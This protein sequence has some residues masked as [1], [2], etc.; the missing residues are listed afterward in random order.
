MEKGNFTSLAKEYINRPGYSEHVLGLLAKHVG[1]NLSTDFLVADVGAGTGKLTENLA[2]LKLNIISIEPND[3]MRQEGIEQT[4]ELGIKWQKGSGEETGLP[5]ASA[6]WILMGSSFHWV[7]TKK[8]LNEFHRALKPNGFFTAIW[9]PRDIE[10]N[11][12]H[13]KIEAQIYEIAPEINRVSSG[14]NKY[15]THLYEDLVSTGQFKDVIFVEAK[16]TI[17]MSQDRYL[18]AWRSV[19]D[20]Q[21]QAGPERFQSILS[22]IQD[23][24][25]HLDEVLVPYRTRSWTAQRVS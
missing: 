9:N 12:L 4:K 22:M 25:K 24:I 10:E 23:E 3:A 15:T 11:E 8:G 17:T 13:K 16:H 21:V 19:N 5:T 1:A 18:G 2:N 6:N 20:I 7:D 14:S